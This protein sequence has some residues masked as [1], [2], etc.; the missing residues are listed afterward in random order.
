MAWAK[1]RSGRL[2]VFIEGVGAWDAE[3]S[4]DDEHRIEAFIQR[5]RDRFAL[6]QRHYPEPVGWFVAFL[7]P[8]VDDRDALADAA[9]RQPEIAAARVHRR[10]HRGQQEHWLLVTVLA[11]SKDAAA[12]AANDALFRLVW[13]PERL[14]KGPWLRSV[15][16]HQIAGLAQFVADELEDSAV[17]RVEVAVL[18]PSV[19]C[20]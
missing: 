12:T 8:E 6:E 7:E 3:P 14:P 18:L 5:A 10:T 9:K 1:G 19:E 15:G 4:P 2:R 17:A 11:H 16:R 20:R 13:P